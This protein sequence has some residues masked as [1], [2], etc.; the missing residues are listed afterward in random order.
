MAA[1]RRCW[2]TGSSARASALSTRATDEQLPAD[3][4]ALA[5]CTWPW[6]WPWLCRAVL[7][8]EREPIPP[9]AA[10]EPAALQSAPEWQCEHSASAGASS[11][12]IRCCDRRR[13]PRR[14]WDGDALWP[15]AA[16]A[17]AEPEAERDRLSEPADALWPAERDRLSEPCEALP[18]NCPAVSQ[19]PPPAHAQPASPT[20]RAPAQAAPR[21]LLDDACREPGGDAREDSATADGVGDRRMLAVSC[22]ASGCAMCTASICECACAC[23]AAP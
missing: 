20:V 12:C 23:P 22:C 15:A 11:W 21:R 5:P 6:L 1:S 3:A 16:P 14:P 18:V 19:P 4:D 10:A 2:C 17:S 7:L 9:A 8:A 13:P